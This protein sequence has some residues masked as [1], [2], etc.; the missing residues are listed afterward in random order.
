MKHFDNF[1]KEWATKLEAVRQ[2]GGAAPQLST[3]GQ[4]PYETV[5]ELAIRLWNQH[6]TIALWNEGRL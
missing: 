6:N 2:I 3:S 4:E 5:K 1:I